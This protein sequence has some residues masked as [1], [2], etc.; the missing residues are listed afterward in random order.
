MMI[1]CEISL[2][3]IPVAH[4]PECELYQLKSLCLF[5]ESRGHHRAFI[6]CFAK[7]RV[8]HLPSAVLKILYAI[9]HFIL[10]AAP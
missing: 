7:W 2:E 6:E 1:L 10:K 9:P 5:S 8:A 3:I 4:V